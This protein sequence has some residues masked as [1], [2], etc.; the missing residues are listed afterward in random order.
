ML[1]VALLILAASVRLHGQVTGCDDSPENPTAVLGLIVS[2]VGIGYVKVRR[3]IRYH[4]K[5]K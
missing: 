3:Y 2:A 4:P 5:G 1:P